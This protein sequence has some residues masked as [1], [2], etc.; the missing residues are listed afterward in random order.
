MTLTFPQLANLVPE[1]VPT[2]I[3]L[4]DQPQAMLVIENANASA[5]ISLF[6]GQV[7]S[8]IPKHDGRDRLWL[9][10]KAIWDGS[11][12]LRGGIPICW[13]WFGDHK[14]K[15]YPAHGYVRTLL[16]KCIEI[17][18]EGDG[19]NQLTQITLV[20]II[21]FNDAS[22]FGFAGKA[23][24][25]LDISIGRELSLV[26]STTNIGEEAFSFTSALHT[27]F[28]ISDIK[29]TEL[30]GLSED[31]S[32][33]PRNYKIFSSPS[34]YRFSEETDRIHLNPVSKV[35][36]IEVKAQSSVYSEGH[37]SI[38]VWNPWQENSR[39]LNDME[40]DDYINMLCVETAITQGVL[41]E[42]G[43]TKNLKQSIS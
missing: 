22:E 27:Y 13:P 15:Q 28:S 23:S 43:I 12:S 6:G 2:G 21:P 33:K 8:F 19:E 42:P 39:Q 26:L 11:K 31:Y 7:L 4:L 3:T 35:E 1:S 18:E 34:P 40:D 25:K 16:W 20:P 14:E 41:L 30:K 24:L 9:S 37:D 36:I 38:V 29:Q 32:D 10:K 17:K 5:T